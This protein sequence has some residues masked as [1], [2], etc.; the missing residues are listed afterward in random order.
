MIDVFRVQCNENN[1]ITNEYIR[2][3]GRQKLTKIDNNSEY[4]TWNK[5]EK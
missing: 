4:N 3:F 5:Y 1:F 2:G